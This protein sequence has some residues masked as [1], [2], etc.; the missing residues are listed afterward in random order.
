M[1]PTTRSDRASHW[2]WG[3]IAAFF[4]FILTGQ[5]WSAN[6]RP[7]DEQLATAVR[8][9][10]LAG[11]VDLARTAEAL[12]RLRAEGTSGNALSIAARDQ[13][14][15]GVGQLLEVPDWRQALSAWQLLKTLIDVARSTA[16]LEKQSSISGN[17]ALV[18]DALWDGFVA[19]LQRDGARGF[20]LAAGGTAPPLLQVLSGAPDGVTATEMYLGSKPKTIMLVQTRWN[21][22][23]PAEA[24]LLPFAAVS[25][26][27]IEQSTF[28]LFVD[29]AGNEPT[30]RQLSLFEDIALAATAVAISDMQGDA[31]RCVERKLDAM[32]S[33]APGRTPSASSGGAGDT[34]AGAAPGGPGSS[35]DRTVKPEARQAIVDACLRTNVDPRYEGRYLLI[36][37]RRRVQVETSS[38]D[39]FFERLDSSLVRRLEWLRTKWPR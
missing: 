33:S 11:R 21:T 15:M 32:R 7:F 31:R 17:L 22:R 20:P 25:K 28:L 14:L 39:A 38:A 13:I 10:G 8:A 35:L 19:P 6:Y 27:P 2:W 26:G 29:I 34:V 18:Q 4:V 3:P 9:A 24:D 37:R 12:G 1:C 16:A 30:H 23:A 5:A 36:D